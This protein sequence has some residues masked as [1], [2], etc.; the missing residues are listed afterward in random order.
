MKL[1]KGDKVV[2]LSGD[3]KG[4]QGKILMS[5]PDKGKLIVEGVNVVKRHTKPS[6]RNQVGGIIEKEAPIAA[7]K[8]A[9]IEP[10]TGKKAKLA[11]KVLENG[12][13]AR[14]SKNT[15]ELV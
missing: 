2:V 14:Y 7:S 1:K 6:Q 9:F 13:R 4:K 11:V 8:V 10:G 12:K 15:N 5:I 3:D